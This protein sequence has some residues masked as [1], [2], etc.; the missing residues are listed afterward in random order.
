MRR[1]VALV[2][3]RI[4]NVRMLGGLIGSSR[5]QCQKVRI[6]VRNDLD[7]LLKGAAC[8]RLILGDNK[9]PQRHCL[10]EAVLLRNHQ[11]LH[12]GAQKVC[13]PLLQ[14]AGSAVISDAGSSGRGARTQIDA[15]S[16]VSG[17]GAKPPPPKTGERHRAPQCVTAFQR[18]LGSMN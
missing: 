3:P 7:D 16:K 6:L 18:C 17:I 14:F 8:H 2:T 11:E 4:T 10:E 5:A 9:I 13:S 1:W 15:R 12:G